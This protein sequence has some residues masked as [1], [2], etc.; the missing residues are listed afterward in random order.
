M[1]GLREKTDFGSW[2]EGIVH[3]DR[4]EQESHGDGSVSQLWWQECEDAGSHPGNQ[5]AESVTQGLSWL[6]AFFCCLLS[7]GIPAHEMMP[8]MF[9]FLFKLL[10]K[11]PRSLSLM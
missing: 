7:L 6:P 8:S 1:Q 10:Q 11:C 9:K 2:L 4:E 5:E 3:R